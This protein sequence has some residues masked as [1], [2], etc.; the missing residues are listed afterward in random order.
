[1]TGTLLA[2]DVPIVKAR[3]GLKDNYALETG[4]F[5]RP[6]IFIE[7]WRKTTMEVHPASGV[8]RFT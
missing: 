3:C 6:E 1:M 5:E 7:I 2:A 4:G 8:V